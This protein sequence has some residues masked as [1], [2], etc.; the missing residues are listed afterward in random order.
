MDTCSAK[1]SEDKLT[2]ASLHLIFLSRSSHSSAKPYLYSKPVPLKLPSAHNSP[3][4]L[5][6]TQI[7]D[8]STS[9]PALPGP[10]CFSRSVGK[11]HNLHFSQ[12]PRGCFCC[13]SADHTL[14]STAHA[15]HQVG[16]SALGLQG[17][18][19]RHQEA[20]SPEETAPSL[21]K[22]PKGDPHHAS[23]TNDLVSTPTVP[24]AAYTFSPGP[25]A[26]EVIL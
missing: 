23:H 3:R 14:R 1:G 16:R 22:W 13:C 9:S 18:S 17:Q 4:G 21:L 19:R 2:V 20:S 8:F 10:F 6:K 11:A 26:L 24:L 15:A 5:T 7:S 25:S 12:A